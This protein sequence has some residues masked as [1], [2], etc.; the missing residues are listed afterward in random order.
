M[1]FSDGLGSSKIIKIQ[2][3]I[4]EITVL[5]PSNHLIRML[6]N[7]WGSRQLSRTFLKVSHE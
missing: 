7:I 4:I 3:I 6:L 5:W 1:K 2:I